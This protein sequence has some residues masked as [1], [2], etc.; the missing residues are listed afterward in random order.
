MISNNTA[1]RQQKNA[2]CLF[3]I[4]NIERFKWVIFELLYAHPQAAYNSVVCF[5][6][7]KPTSNDHHLTTLIPRSVVIKESHKHFSREQIVPLF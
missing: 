7:Q 5:L 2:R 6:Q 1:E 3:V 4:G